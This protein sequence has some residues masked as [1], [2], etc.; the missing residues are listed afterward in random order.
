MN[1]EPEEPTSYFPS[2]P[3]RFR[4][5]FFLFLESTS[6]FHIRYSQVSLVL[7]AADLFNFDFGSRSIE[8][9]EGDSSGRETGADGPLD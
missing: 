1:C 3:A 7:Q 8:E 5:F 4:S 2:S 6:H 9:W